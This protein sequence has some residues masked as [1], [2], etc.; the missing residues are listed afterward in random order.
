MIALLRKT[1]FTTLC[2]FVC[3]TLHAAPPKGCIRVELQGETRAGQEWRAPIGQGWIFRMIPIHP[4]QSP[5]GE[6]WS[7]WDLVV[8]REKPV[9][10]PDALLLATPPYNSI[11]ERELGTTFQL[12]SQDALGWNPRSFHFLTTPEA[13][14]EAQKLYLSLKT[15]PGRPPTASET[16]TM[17]RLL[18]LAGQS[19]SGRLDILD[20]HIAPGMSDAAPWAQNWAQASNRTPHSND[21]PYSGRST[22]HGEIHWVRF[23]LT[24][25]LPA[26]WKAPRELR[27]APATCEP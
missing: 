11:N 21:A 9:G 6:P 25:T 23:M 24:L 1:F 22:A 18:A 16:K 15:A 14:S 17:K 3:T 2:L 8:D 19:A 7:G 13:L 10:F 20:A 26:A 27:T 5:S 12:R 4:A